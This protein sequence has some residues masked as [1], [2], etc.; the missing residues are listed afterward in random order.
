[1]PEALAVLA[2]ARPV[3]PRVRGLVWM[4]ERRWN[5]VLDRDQVVK[6]PEKDPTVALEKAMALDE[7]DQLFRRDLAVVDLRDPR[8]PMLRL[9]ETA[10]Q[11]LERLKKA[12]NRGEDA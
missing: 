4:S 12:K 3:G 6:L 2:E 7:A 10:E 8:R 9:T 1:V 11:E 5:L